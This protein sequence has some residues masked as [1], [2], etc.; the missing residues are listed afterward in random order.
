LKL[1][2]VGRGKERWSC[3]RFTSV[4]RRSAHQKK[5]EGKTDRRKGNG[6]WNSWGGGRGDEGG[7]FI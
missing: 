4:K 6:M 2:V 7:P 3:L 5:K 1:V